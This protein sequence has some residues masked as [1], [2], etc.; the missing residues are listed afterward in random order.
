MSKCLMCPRMCEV[1]R[2]NGERGF[3]GVSNKYVI[4]SA[5]YVGGLAAISSSRIKSPNWLFIFAA[6][7]LRDRPR[8]N[9][10]VANLLRFATGETRKA[11]GRN[12]L[13]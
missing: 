2:K 4:G 11:L 1:D 12:G 7:P 5:D 3:C 10:F 13:R 8:R 9:A 6:G